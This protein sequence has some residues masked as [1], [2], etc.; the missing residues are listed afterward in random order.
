MK[1][2]YQMYNIFYS[3]LFWFYPIRTMSIRE[4]ELAGQ[5]FLKPGKWGRS[6]T[7][8]RNLSNLLLKTSTDDALKF[9]ISAGRIL[10]SLQP[11][12][13][14]E[15][16]RKFFTYDLVLLLIA[17]MIHFLPNL[18]DMMQLIKCPD[19]SSSWIT[20]LGTMLSNIF[21]LYLAICYLC[22]SCPQS[23]KDFAKTT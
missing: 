16:K 17:G 5:N 7:V 11:C 22:F 6:L 23:M 19:E 1:N 14:N 20:G 10:K 2:A 18:G 12:T 8:D 4:L 21:H 13:W 9:R 15:L 3:K